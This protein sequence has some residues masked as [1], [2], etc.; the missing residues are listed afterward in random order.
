MFFNKQIIKLEIS[1]NKK[2]ILMMSLMQIIMMMMMMSLIQ[3]IMMMMIT[4]ASWLRL[5]RQRN[6]VGG[7]NSSPHLSIFSIF[8]FTSVFSK[9]DAFLEKFRRGGGGSKNC[10]FWFYLNFGQNVHKGGEMG[11]GYYQSKKSHC[12]FR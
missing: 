7:W 8:W 9:I 11:R 1:L 12:K 5:V 2:E 6:Q 4:K 3:I 10:M